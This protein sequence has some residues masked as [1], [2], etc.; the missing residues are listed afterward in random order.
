[1][2]NEIRLENVLPQAF[3]NEQQKPSIANSC[4]WGKSVMF[5]A[6]NLYEVSATSGAGKST[7]CA[8]VYGSRNDY[9]GHIFFEGIDIK[10]F[11]ITQWAQLRRDTL[12]YMP[13]DLMLFPEL[14]VMENILLKN[15]LTGFCS[16]EQIKD[17][18]ESLDVLQYA[19]RQT[20]KLSIG[21]QQRVAAVRAICQ[22]FRFL[23]L[24]EPV[25]HLDHANN[26]ALAKLVTE[27]ASR[28]DAAIIVT[29]VGNPL[30]IANP[31]RLEL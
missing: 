22:P 15:N 31:I 25:S 18:L 23:L 26:K 29:S 24:D 17:M 11:S 9:S 4:V 19:D 10:T 1:M 13:Q 16:R 27:A 5:T 2:T 6:G 30:D 3:A 21:Q 20:G 8:Y 7:L 14:T 28:N 12:A